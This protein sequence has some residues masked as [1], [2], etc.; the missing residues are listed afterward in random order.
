[1]LVIEQPSARS[2]RGSVWSLTALEVGS[3]RKV[4]RRTT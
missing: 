3:R 4:C 2:E 1:M